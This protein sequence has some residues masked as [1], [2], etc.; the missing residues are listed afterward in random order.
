MKKNGQFG[1]NQSF[2]EITKKTYDIIKTDLNNFKKYLKDIDV[3]EIDIANDDMNDFLEKLKPVLLDNVFLL[4]DMHLKYNS[5]YEKQLLN[6]N[7]SINEN[8]KLNSTFKI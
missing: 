6:K 8:N 7:V 3:Q 1:L 2:E 5:L 4:F